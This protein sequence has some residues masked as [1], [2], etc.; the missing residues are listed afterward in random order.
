MAV[1]GLRQKKKKKKKRIESID[2]NPNPT[3]FECGCPD[4]WRHILWWIPK[5]NSGL[6]P[7]VVRS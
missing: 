6:A 1:N 4:L 3:M 7:F 2:S 5:E